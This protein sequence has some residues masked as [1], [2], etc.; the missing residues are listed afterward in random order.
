MTWKNID[1]LREMVE[2]AGCGRLTREQVKSAL[3]LQSAIHRCSR[4]A[5]ERG[6]A[7]DQIMC[8]RNMPY[9]MSMILGEER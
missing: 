4:V 9:A 2:Q 3:Q 8:D 5:N 7:I 1:I 6:L